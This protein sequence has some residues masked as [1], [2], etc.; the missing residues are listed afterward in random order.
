MSGL[1]FGRRPR[2]AYAFCPAG[3]ACPPQLIGHVQHYG[4]R[5]ALDVEG[6]GH[7]TSRELVERER[8]HDL[9]DLYELSVDDLK[10]LEGFADRSA[11]KL[12]KAIQDSS[13]PRLDRFLFALGIRH[14]GR[15]VARLLAQS[16]GS[17][18]ELERATREELEQVPEI[19]PE[20]AR[21]VHGFFNEP[22]N[23]QTL[24]RLRE[25]GV[26]VQDMP[27]EE[28]DQ[29]LKGKTFVLT[30]RLEGFTRDEAKERIELLG[31]RATSSVSGETDYLV[32]GEDPGGKLEDAR[33]ADVE[34]LDEEQ[35]E[36]LLSRS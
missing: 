30:G 2:G 29:P 14:V 34:V 35:F 21:S 9:A 18:D 32:V 12:H 31:G 23:R 17:L 28:S 4:S 33:D 16:F 7:E 10:S 11:R 20:I 27:M 15:R 22:S 24:H 13:R 26:E 19:G 5:E 25:S 3:L 36:K 1:R 8:V 6:L